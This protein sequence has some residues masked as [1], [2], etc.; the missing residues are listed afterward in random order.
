[1]K[2][3]IFSF[4]CPGGEVKRSIKFSL[5]QHAVLKNPIEMGD[6][7]ILMG[8]DCLNTKFSLPTLQCAGYNVKLKEINAYF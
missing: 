2:Y 7:I 4:S 5:T 3:S 1:M 8:T 6:G